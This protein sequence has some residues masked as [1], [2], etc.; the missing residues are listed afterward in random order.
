MS[1]TLSEKDMR[2][3]ILG[4]YSI[5][6]T[7]LSISR[8]SFAGTPPTRLLSGTSFVTT[9][10]AAMTTLFPMVTPGKIVTLP[11]IHTSLPIVTGYAIPRCFRLPI[12][13][14]G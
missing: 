9:A 7:S 11:P 10:P 13:V 6:S 1:E 2:L 3:F 12:G 8:M 4:F 14:M 5:F